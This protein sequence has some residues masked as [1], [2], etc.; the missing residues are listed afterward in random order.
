MAVDVQSD[1]SRSG[2]P[3]LAVIA[4]LGW[5]LAAA[6]VWYALGV[7]GS[8]VSQLEAE[9]QRLI[10]EAGQQRESMARAGELQQQADA[11][12]I[13]LDQAMADRS[14]VARLLA[15]TQAEL[16]LAQQTLARLKGEVEGEQ[17]RLAGLEDEASRIEPRAVA[18]K[19]TIEDLDA[20]IASR[21]QELA[22]AT[23]KLD[24]ARQQEADVRRD[25]A[26]VARD[27]DDRR[28]EISWF[29]E[30]TREARTAYADAQQ[31]LERAQEVLARTTGGAQP[32]PAAQPAPVRATAEAAP[33]AAPAVAG[34]SG[35]PV[36]A[37]SGAVDAAGTNQPGATFSD[38][39]MCPEIVVVPAGGFEMGARNLSA[40]E[41]PVHRVAI[42]KAFGIG[43][44]EVTFAEWD[45]CVEEGGCK[46]RPDDRG[47]GRGTHPV[48]G[49][50]WQ[51]AADYAR[52]LSRKSGQAYRLPSEA[53][54]EYAA[55]AGSKTAYW[56]GDEIGRGYANCTGC[57]S[58]FDGKKTAPANAFR[59]NT[60]G[61]HNMLGNAA[62]WV[63]DCWSPSYTGAP[64]D[65]SAWTRDRCSERVLRG[66]AFNQDSEYAQAAARFKYDAGVR[67]YA[68]GFRVV[69]D[70]Q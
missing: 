17:A 41:R 69:R 70:L 5:L 23:A 66:G 20:Q 56:W 50:S 34:T 36:A 61:V 32:S 67:Y 65:G 51:D 28:T 16:Q 53:E 6:S 42:R 27:L 3:I 33:Q 31:Q 43:K 47:W 40:A 55:R 49:V 14:E 68:N 12:Q 7:Q 25:M 19:A 58:E 48:I 45:A 62:E 44:Y 1:V 13:A 46:F 18:A 57:G 30:H 11:A 10:Q 64:S 4:V 22:D 39:E 24:A 26:Q 37:K 54:W 15:S 63:A 2:P 21:T 35:S 59:P 9:N 60:F 52:W 38:C 29:E 8:R